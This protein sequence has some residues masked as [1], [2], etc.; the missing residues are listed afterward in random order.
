MVTTAGALDRPPY[1]A[2]AELERQEGLVPLGDRAGGVDDLLV[3]LGRPR[4][5]VLPAHPPVPLQ[6]V[7]G[8]RQRAF[9][10]LETG[11]SPAADGQP[12][13][14]LTPGVHPGLLVAGLQQRELAALHL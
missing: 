6:L 2:R 7:P 3:R 4:T 14:Q 10:P 8:V 12:G 1:V 13:E 9:Q 5:V 11:Q